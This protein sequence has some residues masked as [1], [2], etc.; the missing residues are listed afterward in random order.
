MWNMALEALQFEFLLGAGH[1]L[2]GVCRDCARFCAIVTSGAERV[3]R[4]NAPV[5]R[6]M[7]KGACGNLTMRARIVGQ[8]RHG[9]EEG[10]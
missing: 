5:V 1:L 9:Q 7:A 6:I 3:S 2:V 8:S 4:R 10:E